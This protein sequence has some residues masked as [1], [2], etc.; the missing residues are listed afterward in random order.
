[1]DFDPLKFF[2]RLGILF[3]SA[4][5]LI[6]LWLFYLFLRYDRIGHIPLTIL[7]VLLML[8]GIQIILFGFLADMKNSKY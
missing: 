3:F 8:I 6:G 1:R 4:G 7:S 2:G 5:F